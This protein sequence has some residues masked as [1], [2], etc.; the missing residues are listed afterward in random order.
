MENE[1]FELVSSNGS[2]D[3]VRTKDPESPSET[4]AVSR[5]RTCVMTVNN[6]D[7]TSVSFHFGYDTYHGTISFLGVVSDGMGK[8]SQELITL[9]Q[10]VI[11]FIQD[12]CKILVELVDSPITGASIFYDTLKKQWMLNVRDAR[13]NTAHW[14]SKTA[15]SWEEMATEAIPYVHASGWQHIKSPAGLDAWEAIF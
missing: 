6:K 5:G 11:D 7:N 4:I 8:I 14:H 10:Q 9:K 1:L 13:W 3:I 2:Q 15:Q 12:D